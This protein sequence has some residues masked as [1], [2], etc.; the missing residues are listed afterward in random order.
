[1][2]TTS[3][4]LHQKKRGIFTYLVSAC[5]NQISRSR[6]AATVTEVA[7]SGPSHRKNSAICSGLLSYLEI[8]DVIKLA[9]THVSINDTKRH[10]QLATDFERA[11]AV[12]C[13]PSL[14]EGCGIPVS[15]LEL[16]VP[17]GL[18]SGEKH[19]PIV[20]YECTLLHYHDTECH[21]P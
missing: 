21:R 13:V 7:S 4:F 8:N 10:K 9:L 18:Q 3:T 19:G 16:K 17:A 15:G 11:L 12:C 20:C 1:M 6:V 14:Q 2:P 5:S